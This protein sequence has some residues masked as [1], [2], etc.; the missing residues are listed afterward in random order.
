MKKKRINVYAMI[1]ARG[2][3]KG[4]KNKNIKNFCGRP[5]ISYSIRSAVRNKFISKVFVSTDSDKIKKISKKYGA[6]VPFKRPKK[7]S[8]DNSKEWFA[9]QHLIRHL[10]KNQD[11]PDVVISLPTTS[12]LRIDHDINYSLKKFLLKKN[13]DVL[14]TITKPTRNPYFN[15]VEI[16]KNN[17]LKIVNDKNKYISNR[18]NAPNVFDISTV[19]YVSTPSFILKS[20]KMFD[21]NVDFYEIPKKRAIDIDTQLD[22][23]IAEYLYKNKVYYDK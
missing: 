5:L 7:L 2:G 17:F 22:F 4:I 6:K 23:D 15:M 10:K 14:I 21:G 20:K 11:L 1:F 3:S 16:K 18:Q 13:S 19:A 8:Q 9:W 12:P